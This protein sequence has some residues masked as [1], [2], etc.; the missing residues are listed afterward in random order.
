M[1]AW[2]NLSQNLK[3][4]PTVSSLATLVA[5]LA[6]TYTGE[7]MNLLQHFSNDMTWTTVPDY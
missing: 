4:E 6:E 1:Y 7:N 3:Q 2:S 5:G